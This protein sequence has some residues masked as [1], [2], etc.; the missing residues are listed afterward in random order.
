M[1]SIG[2]FQAK[3]HLSGLLERVERGEEITITRHG[4]PVARL[5][6]VRATAHARL[7]DVAERLK[8]FRKGRRRGD[9]SIRELIDEG[10][11]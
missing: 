10:H 1:A 6:P 3:T 4:Q 9:I 7:A 8:A 11:R 5:V 2:V